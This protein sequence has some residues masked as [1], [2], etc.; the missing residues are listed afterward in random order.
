MHLVPC[1]RLIITSGAW[2]PHIFSTLFQSKTRIPIAHLAGHSLLLKNP[3]FREDVEEECHAVFAADN[4]GFSPEWF[5]RAGGEVYLAG[6]NTTM[7]PLPE[8]A[9]DAQPNEKAMKQLRDC[10]LEMMGSVDG[11][12]VEVMRE[13]LVSDRAVLISRGVDADLYKQCFRPV[14]ASGRPIISR[15]TD[16]K[17]GP[18]F[19]TKGGSEGGV[20]IA[21]GHGA[22]GITQ[23]CGT[24]LCL[25]ELVEGRETSADI[26]ALAL[27]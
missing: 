25:T 8:T 3:F 16:D 24:G 18:G 11:R 12:D 9:S 20:F 17:L 15:I 27:P 10:A 19:K 13:S 26:T 5:S 4:L 21:S 6:L 2:S 1:T 22:W 7:I 14:T 23:S